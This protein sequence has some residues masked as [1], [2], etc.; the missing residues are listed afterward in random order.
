[1]AGK[2]YRLGVVAPS[3]TESRAK[4]K[5]LTPVEPWEALSKKSLRLMARQGI[6]AAPADQQ[7]KPLAFMFA[8]QG[9]QYVGMG[10]GLYQTF[11][12][13]RKWMDKVAAVADFDLLDLLFNS[14]E[15][16]LQKTRWQQPALYAM[17]VAIVQ[18]L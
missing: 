4:V 16:D 13:I 1:M 5:T 6:F 10:K 2:P 14:T 7:I 9:S 18:N 11:P 15:E 8:G 17:E 3:E 12:G